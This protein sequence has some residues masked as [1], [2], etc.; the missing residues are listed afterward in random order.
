MKNLI[1]LSMY[2]PAAVLA[3]VALV[4]AYFMVTF[5]E[6]AGCRMTLIAMHTGMFVL[7]LLVAAIALVFVRAD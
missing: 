5:A 4:H 7:T 2:L 1:R 3:S 6:T